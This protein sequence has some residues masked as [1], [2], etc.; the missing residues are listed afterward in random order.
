[1]QGY[2]VRCN[3]NVAL[4][5]VADLACLCDLQL[6]RQAGT[7]A[8]VSAVHPL[9]RLP[10]LTSVLALP[11]K[12]PRA[13]AAGGPSSQGSM[14]ERWQ[15]CIWR[16]C[17]PC[18]ARGSGAPSKVRSPTGRAAATAVGDGS[19]PAAQPTR[20]AQL[21]WPAASVASSIFEALLSH[22]DIALERSAACQ[23][24]GCRARTLGGLGSIGELWQ[25]GTSE[26]RCD[27]ARS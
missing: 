3:A 18:T 8:A 16:L 24:E 9:G 13:R 1:M 26:G 23:Q 19:P 21:F 17:R 11:L 7:L 6:G 14:L 5:L 20:H 4:C 12:P 15:G 2:E 10:I 27:S 25:G 22:G